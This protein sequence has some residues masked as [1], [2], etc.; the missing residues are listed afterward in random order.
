L[1]RRENLEQARSRKVDRT[2][3]FCFVFVR[4]FRRLSCR[5][6]VARVET[7]WK[8]EGALVAGLSKEVD[9]HLRERLALLE[10]QTMR[11]EVLGM[12]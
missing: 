12:D 2:F 5:Q 11:R 9:A 1:S 6:S 10:I 3:P 8:E 4:C 7:V